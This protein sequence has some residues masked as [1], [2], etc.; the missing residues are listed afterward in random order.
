MRLKDYTGQEINDLL[1]SGEL[2]I[3]EAMGAGDLKKEMVW[4]G[5]LCSFYIKLICRIRD[6]QRLRKRASAI[7]KSAAP[8]SI[9]GLLPQSED[10]IVVGFN[11]PSLGEVCR[12]LHIGF[13]SYPDREFLFPVNLPWY[14]SMVGVIP[15]LHRLGINITPMITPATEQKLTQRFEGDQGKMD[16][17]EFL[18]MV[19]DRRYIKEIKSIASKKGVIFIAPSATRQKEIIGDYVHPSMTVVA[20]LVLK[21]GKRAMFVPVA[22]VSPI[23]GNRELNLFRR[24]RF[25]PCETFSS[26]EVSELTAGRDRAFDFTFLRRIEKVYLENTSA[27]E[28]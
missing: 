22:V 17:I 18:R 9:N 8:A 3:L 5:R 15:E 4:I 25:I 1:D 14:E 13:D 21:G 16:E 11:H 27:I 2:S 7:I 24:Y 23:L 19:F 28:R 20:H 10:T 12:L 26:E 6:D